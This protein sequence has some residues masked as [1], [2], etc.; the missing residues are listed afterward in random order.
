MV[1]GLRMKWVTFLMW[2]TVCRRAVRRHPNPWRAVQAVCTLASLLKVR[3]GGPAI[4][5]FAQVSGQ[6]FCLPNIPGWPSASFDRFVDGELER[7]SFAGAGTAPRVQLQT[8]ILAITKA[9]PLR[10]EHCYEWDAL[11]QTETAS[12]HELTTVV[13]TFQRLGVSQI[14]LGGGEPLRR[15]DAILGILEKSPAGIDF[16]ILTSG[17][18]LTARR[19]RQLKQ[20][21]LTGVSLSLDHWDPQ[22][23][24][25]F[26]GNEATFR[27]VERAARSTKDSGLVL[28]LS[29]CPTREFVGPDN[30]RRYAELASDLGAD[31]IQILE[32]RAVG[33][34]SGQDV[35][36]RPPEQAILERFFDEMNFDR[37]NRQRPGVVYPELAQRRR[38]CFGAGLL[39]LYVDPDLQMHACPFCRGSVGSACGANLEERILALQNQG[40]GAFTNPCHTGEVARSA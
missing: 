25:R 9:C 32:P 6:F 39:Y 37:R 12:I 4:Q 22:A 11:N 7:L 23:H 27:W 34:F 16:W 10:C 26:R 31:F 3:R 33:H 19:A 15:M 14:Q 40:C 28:S 2:L 13:D 24:N 1:T 36:L 29:L 30:L 38:G 18:G 17:V 8:I 5:K 20:A 35:A 21:G